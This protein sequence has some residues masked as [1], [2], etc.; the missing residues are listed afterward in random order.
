MHHWG[1]NPNTVN[2]RLDAERREEQQFRCKSEHRGQ[3]REVGANRERSGMG[4]RLK[5]DAGRP[6]QSVIGFRIT[7]IPAIERR[8]ASGAQS[9]FKAGKKFDRWRRHQRRDRV[10][11]AEAEPEAARTDKTVRAPWVPR[12]P[13]H[14]RA[15]K[16]REGRLFF[17]L[18]L[19]SR[20]HLSLQTFKQHMVCCN[21]AYIE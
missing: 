10:P 8:T 21:G 16:L 20:A 2:E 12:L 13:E 3:R 15:A 6:A 19:F 17:S 7:S 9:A 11:K 4:E 1:Y 5:T 18:T 14:S